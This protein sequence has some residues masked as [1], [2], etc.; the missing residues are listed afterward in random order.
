MTPPS[1]TIGVEEEYQIVDPETR[2]LRSYITQFLEDGKMVLRELE[3]KPEMHQSMVEMGTP[4]CH[5]IQET[6]AEITRMR[7][8]ISD[9]AARRGLVIAAAG[10]HPFS[11]WEK[12]E[13]TPFPRYYGVVEDM[14]MLARRLLIFGMHVH[15][16]IEDREFAIDT[17]NVLRYM[18]P[19]ILALSTS[20]PF[21]E[22]RDTG[23]KSFRS[24]IFE[25]FPRTGLPDYFSSYAEFENF[26]NILVKTHCIDD[27]KRIWWDIRPHPYFSTLEFR[28]CDMCTKVDE[29]VAIVALFQALVAKHYR[30]RKDNTTFRIYRRDLIAE[31]KWRAVRYGLDGKLLDLGK[32]AEVPTRDL[33]YELVDFVDDVL[34]D[35]GSRRE[36]EYVFK[37]LAEGTSADRQLQTYRETGDLKAVVDRVVAE[38][39]SGVPR[40]ASSLTGG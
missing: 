10:T 26:V 13:I 1:L 40:Q 22:G 17:M 20:S 37:I 16:G 4:I 27:G 6:R 18:T 38:T 33:M 39:V 15:I 32:Q 23:L 11:H 25:D 2:E 28:I 9:L 34:D 36:V 7:S 30:M 21:F 3:L 24:V 35:L 5:D 14:Q 31:N 12:Q 29:A 19:H 8:A